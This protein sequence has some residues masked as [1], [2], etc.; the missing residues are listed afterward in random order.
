MSR[1]LRLAY[2]V[3]PWA[4]AYRERNRDGRLGEVRP[5]HALSVITDL[6]R[7]WGSVQWVGQVNGFLDDPA[8]YRL[9][10]GATSSL[11]LHEGLA[12]NLEGKAAHV[13]DLVN[14]GFGRVDLEE[15]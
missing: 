4:N 10:A 9:S 7:A 11:R 1:Q 2:Q 5:Y 15:D 14:P 12:L 8:L 3:G 6:N 13:R